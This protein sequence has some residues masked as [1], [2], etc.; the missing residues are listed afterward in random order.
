MNPKLFIVIVSGFGAVIT[1]FFSWLVFLLIRQERSAIHTIKEKSDLD[2]RLSIAENS[3]EYIKEQKQGLVFKVDELSTDI[4]LL[5]T[6]IMETGLGL[7]VLKENVVKVE[8][9]LDS[10]D[11]KIDLFIQG[12]GIK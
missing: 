8:N 3:I 6:A 7:K 5:K 2:K 4:N 10:I 9:K 11:T 12:V 1:G